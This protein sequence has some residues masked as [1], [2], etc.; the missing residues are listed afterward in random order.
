MRATELSVSIIQSCINYPLKIKSITFH[1]LTSDAGL[2]DHSNKLSKILTKFPF[3]LYICLLFSLISVT[4][5]MTGGCNSD[6]NSNVK[7]IKPWIIA[8][9][10][11]Q[12]IMY[13]VSI[14]MA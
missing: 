8:I 12:Y 9:I 5:V 2:P 10:A 14:I 13:M 1:S 6:V 11:C 7:R 4:A 3:F